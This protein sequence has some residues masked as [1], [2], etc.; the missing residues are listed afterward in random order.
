MRVSYV[1]I[2]ES[3]VVH[4]VLCAKQQ[5]SWEAQ[6]CLSKRTIPAVLIDDGHSLVRSGEGSKTLT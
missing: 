4:N 6:L 1:P 5:L 2:P 3:H